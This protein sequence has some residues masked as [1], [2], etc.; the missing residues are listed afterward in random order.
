MSLPRSGLLR[1]DMPVGTVMAGVAALLAA[2]IAARAGGITAVPRSGWRAAWL[3]DVVS[4]VALAAASVVA[5]GFVALVGVSVRRPRR[6][7]HRPPAYGTRS[8][9]V[10]AMLTVLAVVA[11]VVAILLTARRLGPSPPGGAT[12][13]PPVAV[14]TPPSPLRDRPPPPATGGGQPTAVLAL[15]ALAAVAATVVAGTVAGTRRC[16]RRAHPSSPADDGL[17]ATDDRDVAAVLAGGLTA[18]TAALTSGAETPRRAV[19]AAYVAMA[20][21]LATPGRVPSWDTPGRL[22][23]RARGLQLIEPQDGQLLVSLFERARFSPH[24]ITVDDR[25]AA[26]HAL[27]AVLASLGPSTPA[28]G[29]RR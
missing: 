28:S 24:P 20:A 2:G 5:V 13:V 9:R 16:R 25:E 4:V 27:R 15:T 21:S 23:S 6:R 18:A 26:E 22:L 8:E 17:A 12:A 7:G 19:I 11:V 1:A 3:T 29:V 14:S 10:V